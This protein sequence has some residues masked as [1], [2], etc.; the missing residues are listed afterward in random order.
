M[1]PSGARRTLVRV[2]AKSVVFPEPGA[3]WWRG[4]VQYD[5]MFF[6]RWI[7]ALSAAVGFSITLA[8][9]VQGGVTPIRTAVALGAVLPWACD[10][11]IL[12]FPRLPIWTE[13]SWVHSYALP[14]IAV[15][16]I[17]L[18]VGPDN[19][20]IGT[21]A[22]IYLMGEQATATRIRESAPL[23]GAA[24]A[25][26]GLRMASAHPPHDS[27]QA[28]V[29]WMI[30][31]CSAW[32]VGIVFQRQV[33]LITQLRAA[34]AELADKAATD[35]RQR[36]ARE[37]H[38]V[39]A[40]SLTVTMLHLTGA[41]LTLEH[42]PRATTEAMAALEEAERLGRQ[43]LTEIRRT[44]GLLTADPDDAATAPLPGTTD[45]PELVA[46]Y[47][48]AGLPVTLTTAGDPGGVTLAAG[49]GL[50]RIV[51]ESLTNVAKHAPGAATMVDVV[52]GTETIDVTVTNECDAAMPRRAT[53]AQGG[54]GIA[55]MRQRA[56]L[57]GGTLTASA[58]PDGTRWSVE[59]LLPKTPRTSVEQEPAVL[60]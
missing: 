1:A 48:G 2:E 44:V 14:A 33:R 39:I 36:I 34:Q 58:T 54:H 7:L 51:Q 19:A 13:S 43:S 50:Y 38:D 15:A 45:L 23:L 59:G 24:L 8:S 26:I 49:L 46:S 52:Y 27:A 25:G 60:A 53:L 16:S 32:V 37:V 12:L 22:L 5:G 17:L 56:Q 35:E 41:R 42:D 31:A 18:L 6:P 57:L 9:L 55:G 11:G 40:H 20:N 28:W 10:A 4:G 47:A 30:G 21:I 3:S 29:G